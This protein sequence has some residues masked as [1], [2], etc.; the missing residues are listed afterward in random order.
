MKILL[1]EDSAVDRQQI[2]AYLKEWNLDFVAVEDG[3]EAWN[4]LQ[5]PDAPTLVLVDWVLP[6][7][8]GIQLCQRIRTLGANGTYVYAVMLTAKDRNQHLLTAMAAGAD[9]YLAKP[10]DPS[11][12]KARLLVAKRILDLQQSLRFA[13]SHDFLTKLLNRAEILAS[14]KRELSRSEREEKPVSIL[15]A[16]L[17]HFKKIND[18]LGHA[19][20]DAVLRDVAERLKADLRSYDLVG[21]Y[22]GE[23]FLII[24]PN[25]G[26]SVATRR[27]D[28]IR[29]LVCKDAVVTTF[30]TV[31]LTVSIGVTA[32]GGTQN[33]TIE[34][35]LQQ[36]DE[37]LYIAKKN[38]RNRVQT[39]CGNHRPCSCLP[40][41]SG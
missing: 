21:R 41:V 40:S 35:L 36:A 34:D 39:F 24:L 6:G 14:L 10:V 15:M 13:A 17:D 33:P 4:L 16:D 3:A 26:L 7:L 28:E 25:C 2:G 11:E 5:K 23:E 32:A 22:G 19:A 18:S 31:P 30:A 29:C 27:A 9:D 1:V 38:G 20:G 12:L 8:D 37:A